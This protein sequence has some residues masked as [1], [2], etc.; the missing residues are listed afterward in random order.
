M[1]VYADS[2]W[3]LCIYTYICI[4]I[5]IHVYVHL[6][7]HTNTIWAFVHVY[8]CMYI[9]PYTHTCMHTYICIYKHDV[10]FCTCIHMYIYIYIYTHT[11][12]HTYSYKKKHDVSSVRSFLIEYRAHV[13]LFWLNIGLI[14]SMR[15]ICV[16][17]CVCVCVCIR[18]WV[19][20][21]E[22]QWYR[23]PKTPRMPY[24][25]TSFSAIRIIISG[26]FAERDLQREAC[27]A[28]SPPCS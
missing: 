9:Y 19:M 14:S 10:S 7:V 26:S 27:Y 20:P 4:H 15:Q 11:C 2:T 16:R 24:R 8:M 18:A 12:I 23:M 25:H 6:C 22:N 28:F 13:S 5:Y 3:A 17:V 21:H 1:Y